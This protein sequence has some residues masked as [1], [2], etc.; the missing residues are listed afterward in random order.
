MLEEFPLHFDEEEYAFPIQVIPLTLRVHLLGGN[1]DALDDS[2]CRK[3]RSLSRELRD[4]KKNDTEAG[5]GILNKYFGVRIGKKQ[6]IQFL[7]AFFWNHM[8][9]SAIFESPLISV[10]LCNSFVKKLASYY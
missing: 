3:I 8:Q 7:L 4:L 1:F 9:V 6:C 10:K 5:H 2:L